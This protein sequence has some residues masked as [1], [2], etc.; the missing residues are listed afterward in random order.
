MKIPARLALA[1]T[2]VAVCAGCN[3][4]AKVS[5]KDIQNRPS[6]E[7]FSTSD[8][9]SE[10]ANNYAYM[11]NIQHRSFVDDWNRTWLID[12]P[13]RLSPYP[14]VDMSGNPR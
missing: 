12:N 14:I 8:R 4:K 6:P 5:D 13:S 3:H 1:A 2:L 11:R 10:T 7:M 9:G